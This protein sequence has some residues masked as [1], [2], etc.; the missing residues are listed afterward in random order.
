MRPYKIKHIPTGYYYQ[1]HKYGGSHLS[2]NGKIYQTKSNGVF[3]MYTLQTGKCNIYCEKNSRIYKDT[4]DKL[5]WKECRWS[6]GQV[7]VDTNLID[8]VIEEI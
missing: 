8:W 3:D 6:Y 4:K 1:P 2:K 7:S 5:E